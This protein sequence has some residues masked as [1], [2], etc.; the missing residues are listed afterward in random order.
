MKAEPRYEAIFFDLF[1]TLV[2]FD[3]E[4]LEE[5]EF[6]GGRIRTTTPRIYE[7]VDRGWNLRLGFSQF[8]DL[9]FDAS[10]RI[11]AKKAGGRE[12][13]S[14][15]RF[16]LI[17]KKLGIQD[18][19]ATELMVQCHMDEMFKSMVPSP[20]GRDLLESIA[21]RKMLASNFDHPPTV[22]RVL[23][24]FKLDSFIEM[25][26]VSADVGWR[27]PSPRFFQHACEES[28]VRPGRCLFVGDDPVA[29]CE[30]AGRAGFQVAWLNRGSTAQPD[31]PPGLIVSSLH[32]LQRIL[33]KERRK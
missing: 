4:K 23:R 15:C 2:D 7:A 20:G 9:F 25:E 18:P 30:G 19:A 26:F 12:F 17:R 8:L 1:G 33:L 10:R 13:P 21:E 16:E 29:D 5:V 22:R 11:E 6:E 27:K 14:E 32:E 24:A 3:S 28:R 31:P